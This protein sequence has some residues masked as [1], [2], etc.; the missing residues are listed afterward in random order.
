MAADI[1][2]RRMHRDVD[3]MVAGAKIQRRRPRVVEHR[4]GTALARHGAD[5]RH[6]L[7][8]ERERAWRLEEHELG[9]RPKLRRNT[10]AY[11]GIVVGHLHTEAAKMQLAEAA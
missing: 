9:I 5:C 2:R 4:D 3:A 1:L 6:I 8:F 11:E 7:H 10:G